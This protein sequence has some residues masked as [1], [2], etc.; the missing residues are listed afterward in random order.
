MFGVK[1]IALLREAKRNVND[2]TP[3]D[4]EAIQATVDEIKALHAETVAT[5]AE[6]EREAL[7][8]TVRGVQHSGA[9]S[10]RV[11]QQSDVCSRC[12]C[13]ACA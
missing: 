12:C 3:Y 1:A 2:L 9:L 7:G 8:T 13:I 6:H 4:D 11:S 5:K 10:E